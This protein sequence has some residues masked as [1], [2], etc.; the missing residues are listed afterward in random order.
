MVAPLITR[1]FGRNSKLVTQGYGGILHAVLE[2]TRKI[3]RVG[4]AGKQR[5]IEEIEQITMFVKLVRVNGM[6]ALSDI[7]G[8]QVLKFIEKKHVAAE[9]IDVKKTLDDIKVIVKK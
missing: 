9:I 3:N 1:G 5:V 2:F 4:R 8:L 6:K 7:K